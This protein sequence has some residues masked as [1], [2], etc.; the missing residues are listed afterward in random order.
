MDK[1]SE[2]FL[3]EIA[4][5]INMQSFARLLLSKAIANDEQLERINIK[6]VEIKGEKQFNFVYEHK[7]RH[8]TRNFNTQEALLKLKEEIGNRFKNAILYTATNDIRLSYN[9]K[10]E[11]RLDYSKPTCT[12]CVVAS[13]DHEKVRLVDM[14]NSLYL[15]EL[16]VVGLQGQ[17]MQNMQGKFRQIGKY[18]ETIDGV[19]K[20]SGLADAATI[21]VADMGSGK[22]YLT[23]AIYDYLVNTLQKDCTVTGVE[24]RPDLVEKCNRI[25][26]KCGF[27]KLHFHQGTIQSYPAG[28]TDILIA[29][30]ACDTATDDAIYQ[31][32]RTNASVIIT[33]PCCHKQIR[34]ELDTRD[35]L[36]LITNY[37]IFEERQ[38]EIVTDTLRALFLEA[39]GYK[40][41]VFEFIADAHTHKN[42]M[43]SGVKKTE[44]VPQEDFINK[45]DLLMK[46]FGI[47]TFYLRN[48]LG[49]LR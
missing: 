33:A 49:Q 29:L 37:G 39:Y 25:A 1:N 47:K 19:I 45:A 44:A 9:K 31:G 34:K 20:S 6:I 24:M 32:I 22:G 15:R 28:K 26:G 36:A 7:T 12:L 48:L 4:S 21:S 43:I 27:E 40:T 2:T 35:E 30:H 41:K 10:R 42:V 23:F 13:H 14:E 17:P 11:S 38:A 18:V 8:I 46:R 3:G 16:G 5:A